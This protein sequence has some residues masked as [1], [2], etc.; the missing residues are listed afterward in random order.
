MRITTSD[1]ITPLG[2]CLMGYPYS[3]ILEAEWLTERARVYIS[4]GNTKIG[5][6]CSYSVPPFATLLPDGREFR[7]CPGA[8]DWCKMR[9]YAQRGRLVLSRPYGLMLENLVQFLEKGKEWLVR[10]VTSSLRERRR[11]LFRVWV[12]GDFFLDI[13]DAGMEVARELPDWRFYTYTRSWR[14]PELLPRLGEL[15]RL[16]NFV[17]YASTDDTSGP[18][19]SGWLEAGVEFTYSK[20]SIKCPELKSCEVCGYCIYGRGHVYFSVR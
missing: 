10:E 17:V 14:V 9:C 12:A 8:T 11:K 4:M 1:I 7:T 16:P 19:P 3:G 18:P 20:P 13:I 6:V 2:P 15:R 5:R